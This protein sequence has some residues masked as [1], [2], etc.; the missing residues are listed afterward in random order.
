M[1]RCGSCGLD[2]VDECFHWRN[3]EKNKRQSICIECRKMYDAKFWTDN[4]EKYLPG[5]IKRKNDLAEYWKIYKR[6]LSCS[7]CGESDP[8]C[9]D[10]H[11]K[12]PDMK[13]FDISSASYRGYSITKVQQEIDKCVV[14]CANCHRKEHIQEY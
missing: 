10:F 7:R 3:K 12:D 11:H 2:K 1:K 8:R 4:K 14:F 5:K 9:L 13:T 6:T